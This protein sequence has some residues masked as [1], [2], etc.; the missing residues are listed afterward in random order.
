MNIT[1]NSFFNARAAAY[2]V[3]Q[4]FAQDCGF[5]NVVTDR[6]VIWANSRDSHDSNIN[7]FGRKH[8]ELCMMFNLQLLN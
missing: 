3:S 4:A 1:C 5:E 7:D 8:F 6:K 2:H